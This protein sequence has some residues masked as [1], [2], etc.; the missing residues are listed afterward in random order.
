MMLDVQPHQIYQNI[1]TLDPFSHR[2]IPHSLQD[3]VPG[4]T[5]KKCSLPEDVQHGLHLATAKNAKLE[6]KSPKYDRTTSREKSRIIC[7]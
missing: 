1:L 3:L 7:Q 2:I 5:Q 4:L 6:P